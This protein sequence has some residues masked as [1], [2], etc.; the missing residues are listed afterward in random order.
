MSSLR[1]AF[2]ALVLSI[3]A[4]LFGARADEMSGD[5]KLRMLYSHRFTFSRDGLPL[6]SVE[7]MH[8]QTEVKLAAEGALRVLPDGEGGAA[9]RSG[10]TWTIGARET[11]PARIQWWTIVSRQATEAEAAT[12]RQRGFKTKTFETGVV[13]GVEG[14]VI[15]SRETLLGVAPENDEAAAKKTAAEIAS[16]HGVDTFVHPH[17]VTR[18]RGTIV[19]RDERGAEVENEG[20]LWFVPDGGDGT[21]TVFDVLHGG[22]GSQVGA[23]K[24]DTRRYRGMIYVTLD[25][26]GRL[27][28]VNAVEEDDLLAGLVPSEIF[29]DAPAEALKAQA[30]AARVEVLSKIGTRHLADPFLLCATQ[31]CQVYGGVGPEDARTTAAVKAT[32]GEVLLRDG[33]GGLVEVYYSASCGG[34]GE[35]NENVWGTPAD[36]S[37]RGH[38]DASGAGAKAMKPFAAGV[39]DENL[40]AFLDVD[41]KHTHCGGTRWAKNRYRWSVTKSTDELDDLITAEFP[42]VGA[43]KE[44]VPV[45]RGISGRV[46]KLKIVGARSTVTVEGELR[47]RRLFGGLRSS[48]FLVSRGAEGWTFD[49]AGFGHGVGMCQTGAIGMA[50]RNAK[51]DEILRHYYPG[52]HLRKLY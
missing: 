18:P 40:R 7:L 32:R 47:I 24:R 43:V 50:E 22:G 9:V 29:P 19:A 48:L 34:F 5:D 37:L 36:P 51:H 28:V 11:K 4:L 12:W 16:K 52:S 8:G 30:I 27:S 49:G 39:T 15:D 25:H 1:M 13:F 21:I 20:V 23:E 35:H 2:A 44:L 38:L 33:G 14:D 41:A 26:E 31:H 46:K 17:L 6:V 45:E 10:S 3:V 42:K